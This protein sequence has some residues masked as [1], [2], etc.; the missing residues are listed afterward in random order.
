MHCVWTA[1]GP[2][3]LVG[4]LALVAFT[5]SG[6]VPSSGTSARSST[7]PCAATA[8]THRPTTE[9]LSFVRGHDVLVAAVSGSHVR[10]AIAAHG[11]STGARW[12]QTWYYDPAWS[13]DGRCLA[14][15]RGGYPTGSHWYADVLVRRDTRSLAIPGGMSSISGSPSW[16]PDGRR[17][18][19][20]GYQ[21]NDGGGLYIQGVGTKT[22][23]ALTPE[24]QDP[25]TATP[26]DDPAWSPDGSTIAFVR[27]T[28]RAPHV[29]IYL[30]RPDGTKLRRL[31]TLE[32]DYPTWSPD[33]KE[34][35][36]ETGGR[37]AVANAD[38][39]GLRFLTSPTGSDTDP[40]WSPGGSAIAFVRFPTKAARIA[41]VW[42]MR[43]DGSDQRLVIKNGEQPAW[44]PGP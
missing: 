34:L 3:G 22:D 10:T 7:P 20:V 11:R 30:I 28:R 32:A 9:L 6:T 39:S 17:L 14:M 26:D 29:S 15:T 24:D 31:T 36:F 43:L 16:A 1:F 44:K 27:H 2:A 19:V 21:W 41:E 4:G 35:A 38:G 13:P 5:V 23:V 37:I 42:I 8:T 12:S 25:T 33:S 18:V 40:A